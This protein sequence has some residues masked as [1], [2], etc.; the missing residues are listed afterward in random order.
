MLYNKC[1]CF[2]GR[3][4]CRSL[5]RR[6]TGD[7][8]AAAKVSAERVGNVPALV[9]AACGDVGA[10]GVNREDNQGGSLGAR[11]LHHPACWLGTRGSVLD[12]SYSNTCSN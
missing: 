7:P 9:C 2:K 3:P 6:G 1:N 4:F 12:F 8:V 11:G 5:K 10:E